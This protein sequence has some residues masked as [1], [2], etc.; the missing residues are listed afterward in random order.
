MDRKPKCSECP[1]HEYRRGENF[2]TMQICGLEKR[3][4]SGIRC[5]KTCPRWCPLAVKNH[6]KG[7]G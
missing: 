2:Y 1:Y 7:N 3:R 6:E 4:F 5:P